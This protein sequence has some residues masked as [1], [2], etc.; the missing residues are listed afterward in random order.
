[1]SRYESSQSV[2]SVIA[3]PPSAIFPAAPLSVSRPP[4]PAPLFVDDGED[5]G[6]LKNVLQ[7]LVFRHRESPS[8]FIA[9]RYCS[10][11]RRRS[12]RRPALD[13]VLENHVLRGSGVGGGRFVWEVREAWRA[14]KSE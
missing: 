5:E 10:S 14:T 1:M 4:W 8:S 9:R 11:P 6:R 7:A 12:S 2:G 13:V 3:P